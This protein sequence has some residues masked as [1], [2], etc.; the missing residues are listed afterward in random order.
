MSYP[1]WDRTQKHKKYIVELT[2]E[3]RKATF[4]YWDSMYNLENNIEPSEYDVVC[5]LEWQD[6]GTFENFCDCFGYDIDSI[7]AKKIY[8][9][10]DD[11]Y[12]ELL[13]LVG[14]LEIIDEI[15]ELI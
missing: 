10:C 4:D 1:I 15:V 3:D 13:K 14:N 5:C 8:D 2:R 11:Q 7:K 6:V 12:F 9:K